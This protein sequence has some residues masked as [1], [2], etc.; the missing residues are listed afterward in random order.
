MD[1]RR[2]LAAGGIAVAFGL[3]APALSG[4]GLLPVFPRRPEPDAE[5]A[6]GWIGHR[7][8]RYTLRLPRAEIGQNIG[9]ALKQVAAE[10]LGAGWDEIDVVAQDTATLARVRATVGSESVRDFAEPLA[11]ACATLRDALAR[12][13]P[14]GDLVAEVRPR[15]ALRAFRGRRFVGRSPEPD[16]LRDIVAG[17]PLF[18]A[19]MTAPDMAH[20]RVLRAA[21]S[22]ETGSRPAAWNLQAARAVPGFVAV[23]ESGMFRLGA[24]QGLG[25]VAETPGALDRIAE[26]LDTEWKI[27]AEEPPEIATAIDID[28]VD[29]EPSHSLADDGIAGDR[30]WHVDLRLDVPAAAHGGIEP[31][32]ALAVPSDGGM[33]VWTGTQ[34]AFYVRDV[35]ARGLGLAADRVTVHAARAGGA[36]GAR[37][38]CTVEA[39]A[40]ALAQ[41]AGRPVKVRW[42]R[43]Q[44]YAQ[45]FHRPPVSHRLRLRLGDSSAGEKALADWQHRLVSSHILFT[46][47]AVPPWLQALTDTF[48]GDGGVARGA[49]PPYRIARRDIAYDLVR[50]PVFTGPWRGLGAGPN[51]L[52]VESAI[53]EA[54]IAAGADPL[55]FRLAHV[56]EPRL[57][58][59]LRRLAE[60][61]DW[62]VPAAPLP[63][64]RTGRGLACGTYKG[65]SHAAAAADVAVAPDGQALVTRLW[66]VHDCGAI[67]NPDQVRAQV[68]GNLAWGLSMVLM[69]DLP[70]EEGAVAAAS[71]ADAPIPRMSD[72]PPIVVDLVETDAPP[73]GAG[74]TAI[75]A[76][77]GAIANAV[78][79]ATGIRP[80]RFPLRPADF[81]LA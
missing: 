33:A 16:R 22:P 73:A 53:D 50:L 34:D 60:I 28:R 43:A 44:E 49:T 23:A 27:D 80:R 15:S 75:A 36:F 71:F 70:V 18:A 8:G 14:P 81:A 77:P 21:V 66:C 45:G 54:A 72:L 3:A 1:R 51:G 25:I 65:M 76:A 62:P 31:R 4:C 69:D 68:E 2:F 20:G 26:A 78:R 61:A 74:E 35:L 37:T 19:D 40:A 57:A 12:G 17:R 67:I 6:L 10:E 46:N 63:G 29:A 41:A 30:R 56:A 79:A 48:V 58:A 32:A 24:S 52:A 11:Q 38:I 42:T 47:A 13:T 9:T 55:A 7:D 5:T 59:V 39:E 64:F